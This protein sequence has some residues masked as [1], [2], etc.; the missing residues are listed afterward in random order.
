VAVP[1]S[2]A[3]QVRGGVFFASRTTMADATP[4]VREEQPIKYQPAWLLTADVFTRDSKNLRFFG[5][6][7]DRI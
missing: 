6:D 1:V 2:T 5:R 3:I 4:S 7:H